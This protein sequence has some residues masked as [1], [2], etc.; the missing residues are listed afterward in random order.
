M[1]QDK[2]FINNIFNVY[3][4]SVGKCF[5]SNTVRI[6]KVCKFIYINE[7]KIYN[8]STNPIG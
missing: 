2:E 6:N 8:D 5:V 3:T 7:Y 4:H 1:D